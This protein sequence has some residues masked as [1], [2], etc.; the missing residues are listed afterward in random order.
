M[1]PTLE[2]LRRAYEAT[3]RATQ[4]TP[5]LRADRLAERIGAAAAYVKPESLQWAGSFKLRGA[6]WRL[7]TLGPAERARGVIAYSSG[8][9]AQGLAAAGQSLGVPVTIVMPD[10]AP[11]AKR[12]ATEGYGARVVLSAHGE[13]PREEVA[14]AMARELAAEEGLT[15]LHPFDDPVIVAGQGGAGLEALD[16]L[17]QAGAAADAVLVSVGGGGLVG[18]VSL[19]FHYLSPATRLYAVEPEGFNSMGV[20]LAEGTITRVVSGSRTICDALQAPIPGSAPF[21]AARL[22]GTQGVTVTDEA[23]R[24]AMRFAFETLKLVLEPSGAVALAAA[25]DRVVD[26]RGQTALIYATGGN[27]S[28]EDFSA[29]MA[30]A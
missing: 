26:L 5:L 20:S 14:A 12:R 25:L 4:V 16:Q 8:N 2:D 10:D 9:F 13:R 23:V 19:A 3:R 21:E 29:H 22:A 17:G 15:L 24:R 27:I 30:A 11:E 1:L 18:G 7:A 28:L 6:Y